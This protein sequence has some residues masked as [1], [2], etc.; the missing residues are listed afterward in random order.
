MHRSVVALSLSLSLSLSMA[1]YRE[2]LT[3]RFI[4]PSVARR[5]PLYSIPHFNFTKTDFPDK[6]ARKG[7]GLT[8]LCVCI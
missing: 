5:S 2:K 4:Y 7:F 3:L 6:E 1:I 8:R